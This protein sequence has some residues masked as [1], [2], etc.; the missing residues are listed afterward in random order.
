MSKT[1]VLI[2]DSFCNFE[3]SVALEILALNNREIV[4][5]AKDTEVVISEEGLKILPDKSIY[6]IDLAEFDS[7][8]L[9]G[10]ADI[11]AA[12]KDQEIIEFIKNFKGKIIGAI[13]I[14]PIL[15]VKASILNGKS[16]MAGVNKEDLLEEGF[17]EAELVKMKDWNDCIENPIEDGYILEDKIITSVSYNFV[18]FGLQFA[19]M[20]GIEI[21]PKSFGI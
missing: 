6:D 21:S 9:P 15:L 12:V 13:S 18:K 17:L 8:L 10:A 1:A 5:F 11:E 7:L 19:K 14:A 2:Y 4:V 3:I 20:L 16:F